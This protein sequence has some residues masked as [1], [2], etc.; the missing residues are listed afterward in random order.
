MTPADSR[1]TS[2]DSSTH[3]DAT[4]TETPTIDSAGPSAESGAAPPAELVLD[5]LRT[6]IAPICGVIAFVYLAAE[7]IVNALGPPPDRPIPAPPLDTLEWAVFVVAFG[8][9]FA[10]VG[11]WLWRVRLKLSRRP[12]IVGGSV[13]NEPHGL[14]AWEWSLI[15]MAP[16]A[17]AFVVFSVIFLSLP[18]E[19]PL[20]SLAG[21]IP[22]AA[23]G[24][25]LF[26]GGRAPA[27]HRGVRTWL[28]RTVRSAIRTETVLAV[29]WSLLI[30]GLGVLAA[31]AVVVATH[32]TLHLLNGLI[33]VITA[34][35]LTAATVFVAVA[36]DLPGLP[37]DAVRGLVSG[38][39]LRTGCFLALVLVSI[40]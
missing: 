22:G 16:V 29:I 2:V 36:S 39:A 13:E 7:R 35:V 6:T 17:I 8:A 3:L 27:G 25:R 31:S 1:T 9:L 26:F 32:G 34:V 4:D 20:L 30:V 10:A 18:V 19:R 37:A 15:T 40:Q 21:F 33:G 38:V 23:L 11:G 24:A 12:L 14:Q 28:E 5:V